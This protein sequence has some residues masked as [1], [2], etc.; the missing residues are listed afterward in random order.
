MTETLW[1]DN[2]VQLARD[3][4]AL[5]GNGVA[6]AP[7]AVA[8]EL[9][10]ALAQALGQ[11]RARAV[12]EPG[13]DGEGE[14]EQQREDERAAGVVGAGGG[15]DRSRRAMQRRAGDQLACVLPRAAS[16]NTEISTARNGTNAT[17]NASPPAIVVR[18]DDDRLEDDDRERRPAAERERGANAHRAGVA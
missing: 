9:Q 10:R 2:V 16:V 4:P 12:A 13:G 15:H 14:A 3:P 7:L 8:L 18:D 17:S 11:A 1:V 5:G 6:R